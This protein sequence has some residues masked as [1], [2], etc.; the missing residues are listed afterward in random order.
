MDARFYLCRTISHQWKPSGKLQR[1]RL[2]DAT[3]VMFTLR[4]ANRCGTTREDF[5]LPDSGELIYRRYRHPEGYLMEGVEDPLTRQDFRAMFVKEAVKNHEV[6]AVKTVDYH[7]RRQP[8]FW[9]E[10]E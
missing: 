2:G 1:G 5:I 10:E 8:G 4:C 7:P 6:Q 3:V 9:D